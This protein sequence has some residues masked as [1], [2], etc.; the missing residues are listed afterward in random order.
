MELRHKETDLTAQQ[1]LRQKKELYQRALFHGWIK[2]NDTDRFVRDVFVSFD[3][4]RYPETKCKILDDR[5]NSVAADTKEKSDH[6]RFYF[7]ED[8]FKWADKKE[9]F[10]SMM[11]ESIADQDAVAV[12]VTRPARVDRRK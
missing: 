6:E 7:M 5:D 4:D 8:A 9:H 11:R 10:Q 3:G 1:F 12:T 2:T